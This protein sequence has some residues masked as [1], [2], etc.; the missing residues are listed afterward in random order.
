MVLLFYL[1][2]RFRLLLIGDLLKK[3]LHL[4]RPSPP[5]SRNCIGI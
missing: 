4:V 2:E 5:I 3:S 1:T